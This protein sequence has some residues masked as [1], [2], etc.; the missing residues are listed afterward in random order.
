M[1]ENERYDQQERDKKLYRNTILQKKTLF[2][3]L[4]KK[5]CR[6]NYE[7]KLSLEI[8]MNAIKLNNDPK[9]SNQT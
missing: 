9:N 6:F 7:L 1:A 3:W 8:T 4:L 5:I 2:N